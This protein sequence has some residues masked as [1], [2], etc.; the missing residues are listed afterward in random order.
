MEAL[1]GSQQLLGS[2]D[3][4]S[5]Q[6]ER[7][8]W[9]A[10]LL[11][12][13]WALAHGAWVWFIV[14]SAATAAR[15]VLFRYLMTLPSWRS[16]SV[17]ILLAVTE[18]LSLAVGAALAV[19]ANRVVW[20]RARTSSA[21][22]KPSSSSVSRY[23]E[24]QLAWTRTGVVLFGLGLLVTAISLRAGVDRRDIANCISYG[25]A[26]PLILGL[27]RFD[28]RGR[29]TSNPVAGPLGEPLSHGAA[30]VGEK[31]RDPDRE[32]DK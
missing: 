29:R 20:E 24:A 14:I 28:R 13:L 16:P 4:P 30:G 5:G 12:W 25:F 11:P 15:V 19:S 9:G 22:G 2:G 23:L 10:L 6:L 26:F 7:V 8:N 1:E 3:F 32:H 21:R 27:W 17:V 31:K 18:A